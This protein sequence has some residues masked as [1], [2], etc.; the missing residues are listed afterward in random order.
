MLVSKHL[1]NRYSPAERA[2]DKSTTE[3]S[4]CCEE[5]HHFT[6]L[7]FCDLPLRRGRRSAR[8]IEQTW[9]RREFWLMPTSSGGYSIMLMLVWNWPQWESTFLWTF[10]SICFDADSTSNGNLT[11]K[12]FS[13]LLKYF[14]MILGIHFRLWGLFNCRFIHVSP[15]I[16]HWVCVQ[17]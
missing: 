10:P 11:N 7:D 17:T 8:S 5:N 12:V 13:Q 16:C 9:K 15:H 2:K 14:L 4:D 3:R 6:V 1:S